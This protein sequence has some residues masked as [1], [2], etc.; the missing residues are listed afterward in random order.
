MVDLKVVELHDGRPL[1]NDIPG[2]LRKLADQ[3]EAG[4]EGQ[5]DFAFV[6]LDGPKPMP[7]IYGYG[8]LPTDRAML[9]LIAQAHEQFMQLCRQAQVKA[10]SADT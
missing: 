10:E 1:L 2:R 8:P 5:I 4:D 3:I 9:G 7:Q 6:V